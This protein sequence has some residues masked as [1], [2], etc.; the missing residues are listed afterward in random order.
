VDGDDDHRVFEVDRDTTVELR[1]ITITRGRDTVGAGLFIGADAD[2]TLTGCS[3]TECTVSSSG[4]AA[5][6][7]VTE[8]ALL[9]L[10]D[11]TISGNVA[12]AAGGVWI[13][14]G[15]TANVR[16]ST[17]S[18]NVAEDDVSGGISAQGELTLTNS[19]LSANFPGAIR[20]GSEGSTT[21]TQ[22]TIVRADPDAGFPTISIASSGALTMVNSVLSGSCGS[23]AAISG[24][25]NIE[26]PDDTCGL[27]GVGDAVGVSG[28]LLRLGPLQQNGGPTQTHEP[29]SGSVAIDAIDTADC[30]VEDD[31]RGVERPQ[32]AGC[33]VGAVEVVP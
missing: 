19:T 16:N 31:Q 6:I 4:V 7:R 3:I 24:G 22:T 27:G 17:I 18:E 28:T 11:S 13:D 8:G 33:D 29:G 26:S 10:V 9:T 5:G 1:G 21:L 32:G 12:F 25:N 2:V 15:A 23:D 20:V 14:S 30:E